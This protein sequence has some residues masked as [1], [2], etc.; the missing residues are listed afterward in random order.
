MQDLHFLRLWDIYSP[1]LTETQREVTNL[2]FNCDLSLSEIAEQKGCSRQSV[3]DCLNTCRKQ[4]EE[5][6]AKLHFDRTL[7][8][9][10]LAHSFLLTDVGK[11]AEEF[12]QEYRE[13][14]QAICNRDYAQEAA[15][16]IEAQADTLL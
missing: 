11:A 7:T 1:L 12:P 13:K 9:L 2:Y 16:A 5:Y 4:L 14:L 6:D 10:S 15:K 8:E 3:S